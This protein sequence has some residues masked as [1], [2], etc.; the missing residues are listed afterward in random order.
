MNAD[1]S[2]LPIDLG[3]DPRV[4][5]MDIT[6]PP[7][8]ASVLIDVNGKRVRITGTRAELIEAIRSAGYSPVGPEGASNA[9]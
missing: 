7:G 4:H 1:L 2:L 9:D 5:D 8:I 3:F 6:I